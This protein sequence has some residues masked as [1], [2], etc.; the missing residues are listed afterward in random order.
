MRLEDLYKDYDSLSQD[1]RLSFVANY[2]QQRSC[3]IQKTETKS[4]VRT[5]AVILTEEEKVLMKLL[6]IKMKDIQA[7]KAI[8]IEQSTEE[9]SEEDDAALFDEDSSFL[10]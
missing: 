8:Q 3:D 7:L 9:S 2:R 10:E 5:P 4:K 6:G 1:E